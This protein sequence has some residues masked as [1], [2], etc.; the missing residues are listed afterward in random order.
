MTKLRWQVYKDF[1]GKV[2]IKKIESM[3]RATMDKCSFKVYLC[4]DTLD[5]RS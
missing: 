1:Y 3:C 4:F 2:K 5:E